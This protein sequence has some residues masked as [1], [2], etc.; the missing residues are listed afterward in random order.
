MTSVMGNAS[1]FAPRLE[2]SDD[3]VSSPPSPRVVPY[4]HIGTS[5]E[6]APSALKRLAGSD[7]SM[8]PTLGRD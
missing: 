8:E 7:C 3:G 4:D 6:R 1:G 2:P 5:N